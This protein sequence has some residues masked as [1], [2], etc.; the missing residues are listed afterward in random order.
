MFAA[1]HLDAFVRR[2]GGTRALSRARDHRTIA[3]TGAA[4]QR[5]N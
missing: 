4:R 1:A 3:M 2:T 5:M